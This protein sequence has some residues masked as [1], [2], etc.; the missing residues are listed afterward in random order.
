MELKKNQAIKRAVIGASLGLIALGAGYGVDR[1]VTSFLI[2]K[3]DNEVLQQKNVA[4]KKA[5]FQAAQRL[6]TERAH[7]LTTIVQS[8]TMAEQDKENAIEQVISMIPTGHDPTI[9][10]QFNEMR[11]KFP[12]LNSIRSGVGWFVGPSNQK[13]VDSIATAELVDRFGTVAFSNHQ[14]SGNG[15]NVL[16]TFYPAPNSFHSVHVKIVSVDKRE[17]IAFGTIAPKVV[18][19]LIAHYHVQPVQWELPSLT[20]GAG[21]EVILVGY[22]LGIPRIHAVLGEEAGF[23]KDPS[24]DPCKIKFTSVV[25]HGMSGGGAFRN[26]KFLGPINIG[27]PPGS[28]AWG[29][30][31]PAASDEIGYAHTFPKRATKV[32]LTPSVVAQL[33]ARVPSE[34]RSKPEP[35][36]LTAR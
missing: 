10:G 24:I 32:G 9:S 6:N 22:P 25:F 12:W 21:K 20:Q 15:R 13:G 17:D 28:N 26:G 14:V 19:N 7:L 31:T 16:V 33:E 3:H 29:G 1:G 34:C 5:V 36:K 11:Y 27:S 23:I 30:Y 8:K 2:L 35:F 4:L 18:K